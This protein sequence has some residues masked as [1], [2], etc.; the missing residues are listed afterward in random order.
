MS[1]VGRCSVFLHSSSHDDR[2]P[3]TASKN[4]A[5]LKQK[6]KRAEQTAPTKVG[7]A[8]GGAKTGDLSCRVCQNKFQSKNKLFQHLKNSGH[9]MQLQ[10]GAEPGG[11]DTNQTAQNKKKRKKR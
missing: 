6:G 10:A 2:R 11:G 3:A 4:R 7:V 1:S 8:V 5:K 9:A